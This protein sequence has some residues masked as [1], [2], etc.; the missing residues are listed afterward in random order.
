M[1]DLLYDKVSF[2]LFTHECVVTYIRRGGPNP[3]TLVVRN[4][5]DGPD[6][7]RKIH[8]SWIGMT[9]FGIPL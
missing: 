4:E 8:Y 6:I 1:P 5:W 2:Y 7:D 9:T 3:E